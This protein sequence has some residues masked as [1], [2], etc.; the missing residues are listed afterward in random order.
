M[1]KKQALAAVCMM[2]FLLT[3]TAP[4]SPVLAEAVK[5]KASKEKQTLHVD[6][7]IAE[8]NQKKPMSVYFEATD[9]THDLKNGKL[10]KSTSYIKHWDNTIKGEERIEIRE[11]R[12]IKYS[13]S[14]A[15]KTTKY[16][17]GDKEGSLYQK[18]SNSENNVINKVK[19]DL[20]IRI[21]NKKYTSP[22]TKKTVHVVEESLLNRPVYHISLK[23]ELERNGKSNVS[24]QDWWIDK[25]TGFKLK[26]TGN[27]NNNRQT[28]EYTVTKV[29][30]KPTFSEKDFTFELPVGVTLVNEKKLKKN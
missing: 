17:T 21:K 1:K 13:V 23:T 24:Y 8:L 5:N 19:K 26:S 25:E 7:V 11:N 12:Q 27:W 4:F 15:G 30:F 6:Q 9:I 14:K 16:I 22:D 3:T 28:H 18:G 10:Q 29:N 2:A 20:D